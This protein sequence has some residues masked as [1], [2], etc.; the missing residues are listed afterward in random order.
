MCVFLSLSCSVAP[1]CPGRATHLRADPVGD[2]SLWNVG[3]LLL[4]GWVELT[5]AG[6]SEN[7]IWGK[8]SFHVGRKSLFCSCGMGAKIKC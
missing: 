5:D 7:N 4:N 3:P 2:C 1:I 6:R 8:Y